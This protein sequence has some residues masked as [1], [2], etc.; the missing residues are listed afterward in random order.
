MCMPHVSTGVCVYTLA[1]DAKN[2][3]VKNIGRLLLKLPMHRNRLPAKRVQLY[4]VRVSLYLGHVALMRTSEPEAVD[5][6]TF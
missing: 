2:M 4:G 1:F 3:V 6:H 5:T